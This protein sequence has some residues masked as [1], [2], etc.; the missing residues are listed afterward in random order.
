LD[1]NAPP[2]LKID[3]IVDNYRNVVNGTPTPAPI[4]VY[5]R[6]SAN[7][8]SD[9]VQIPIPNPDTNMDIDDVAIAYY[10]NRDIN[11]PNLPLF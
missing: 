5:S 11:I 3:T 9:A 1:P 8:W 4:T 6:E 7:A 10:Q 2:L